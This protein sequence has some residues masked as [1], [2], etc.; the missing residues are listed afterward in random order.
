MDRTG[1]GAAATRPGGR[2]KHSPP[3]SY[4][5]TELMKALSD[6]LRVRIYAYLC[7]R[8]A[9]P[10]EIATA[11]GERHSTVRYH[12][13]Q[14]RAGGWIGDDPSVPGRGGHYRAIRGMVI[15]PGAWDRLPEPGRH[16]LAIHLLRGLYADAGASIESGSFLRSG[17]HLSL[18]PM[19]VDSQGKEDVERVL[20]EALRELAGIQR[21][22]DDRREA[23]GGSFRDGISLTAG[24]MG[25]ESAR[26]PG[27]GARAP[28]T[29]RL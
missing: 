24:L 18:T 17:A 20:E 16:K 14:L 12:V 11:L 26:D 2:P 29:M 4:I 23:A 10:R 3:S 9:G 22:S 6:E 19:V 21:E 27:E 8:A 25:F 28:A 5:D 13:D 15:S 7:D 1:N